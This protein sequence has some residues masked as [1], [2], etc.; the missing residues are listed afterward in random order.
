MHPIENLK[1]CCIR[2]QMM[3]CNCYSDA[4]TVHRTVCQL[5]KPLL[6]VGCRTRRSLASPDI[7]ITNVSRMITV[8]ESTWL[9]QRLRPLLWYQTPPAGWLVLWWW[10]YLPPSA[11]LITHVKY[12]RVPG[13][14]RCSRRR[15]RLEHPK[16]EISFATDN[17]RNL[18]R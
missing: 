2:M 4:Y 18:T 7:L 15:G 13:D 8:Y 10:G 17:H 9:R 6:S 11:K 14:Y 3:G 12:Y 5:L 1:A 16:T